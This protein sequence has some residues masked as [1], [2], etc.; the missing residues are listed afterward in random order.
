MLAFPTAGCCL[1]SGRIG[2]DTQECN[3][4]AKARMDAILGVCRVA[5]KQFFVHVRD[6]GAYH[7]ANCALNPRIINVDYIMHWY[8]I[9]IFMHDG[10]KG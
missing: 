6:R 2:P 3:T 10:I 9:R 4:V 5:E 1:F 8:A 7:Y